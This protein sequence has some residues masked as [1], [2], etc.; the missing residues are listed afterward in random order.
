[1]VFMHHAGL[2]A[3]QLP[4]L[5]HLM[6]ML[7]LL[8]WHAQ[9]KQM[10]KQRVYSLKQ[11]QWQAVLGRGCKVWLSWITAHRHQTHIQIL[12]KIGEAF[13]IFTHPCD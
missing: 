6:L 13:T 4:Q 5:K 9:A 2:H 10:R 11:M 7:M 1:M 8:L 12:T 3:A